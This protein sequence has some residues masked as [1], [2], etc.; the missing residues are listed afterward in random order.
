MSL[1]V[2]PS[3]PPPQVKLP[4]PCRHRFRIVPVGRAT[5]W[6]TELGLTRRL[7]SGDRAFDE[8]WAVETDDAEFG[9]SLVRRPEVR[10]AVR[11]LGDLGGWSVSQGR[12]QLTL[13]LEAA[14]RERLREPQRLAAVQ[15]ALR[16][17][18]GLCAEL[19]QAR[20][21]P[22]R[23]LRVRLFAVLA[24]GACALIAGAAALLALWTREL[25]EGEFWPLALR[26]LAAGL[27]L[28]LATLAAATVP[29]AGRSTIHKEFGLL[30]LLLV[31]GVIMA[32]MAAALAANRYLD[33]GPPVRHRLP[34]LAVQERRNEK[35]L[36]GY[37]AVVPDWHGGRGSTRRISFGKRSGAALAAGR[38][39]LVLQVSPGRLGAERVLFTVIETPER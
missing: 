16:E 20:R 37:W 17:L 9:E 31:P 26:S 13:V 27:P 19:E 11:A 30:A 7:R 12:R 3:S 25:V 38:S 15:A 29:L 2:K 34:V 28:A 18:Q 35:Q 1:I 33:P 32:G 4:S 6:F 24:I 23:R 10:Q 36:T 5:R 14:E 22:V 21:F 8:R 39:E